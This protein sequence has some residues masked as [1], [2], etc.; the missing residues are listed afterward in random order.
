MDFLAL[1]LALAAIA[2]ARK[3]TTRADLFKAELNDLREVVLRNHAR[4]LELERRAIAAGIAEEPVATP[5][6]PAAPEPEATPAVPEVVPSPWVA[7]EPITQPVLIDDRKP[8]TDEA[9]PMRPAA[10]P[11]A[12]ADEAPGWNFEELFG[13][14]LPVWAGG[15]AL[16][17]AGF[18]LVKY[19]IEVGLV[20]PAVRSLLGLLFGIGL[21]AGAEVARRVPR[22]AADPRVAQSLSGAGVASLYG[23]AYMATNLYGLIGPTAGF[24]AMAAVTVAALALSLR[25]GAPTALLGLLGGFVAP[26]LVNT[27]EGSVPALLAYLLLM[28][29]GLLGVA[30][31]QGWRWLGLLALAGGFGWSG[32]LLATDLAGFDLAGTGLYLVVLAAGALLLLGPD[33]RDDDLLTAAL[34]PAGAAVVAFVQLAL[35]IA[36]GGFGWTEWGL[37]ALLA[38]GVTVLARREPAYRLLPPAALVVA[39]VTFA[40]WPAPAPADAA[41]VAGGLLL[42]FALPGAILS[43]REDG[44]LWAG[45]AVAATLATAALLDAKLGADLADWQGAILTLTLAGPALLL[46]IVSQRRF[47]GAGDPRP[48][49]FLSTAA[50]LG[51]AAAAYVVPLLILPAAILVIGAGVAWA[52]RRWADAWLP[53]AAGA[54]VAAALIALIG[55][56]PGALD[57]IGRLIGVT[58]GTAP[59]LGLCGFLLP[60]ALVAVIGWLD[61]AEQRRGVYAALAAALAAAAAVQ[62]APTDARPV[63]LAATAAALVEAG[64]R[65]AR[66]PLRMP[67]L[68]VAGLAALWAAVPT[69]LVLIAGL[70]TLG[71]APL[72][73]SELPTLGKT[74]LYLA[75]PAAVLGALLWRDN[76]LP[77]WLAAVPAAMAAIAAF[78][79]YKQLFAIADVDAFAARGMIERVLLTQSLFAAG[80]LAYLRRD[81]HALMLPAGRALMALALARLVWF[82]IL[83]FNPLLQEQSVGPWPVANLLPIA[84][85]LPVFWLARLRAAEP[86]LPSRAVI[87]SKGLAVA[88]LVLLV[89]L[90]VRQLFQGAVLTGG[91]V[92]AAEYYAYSLAGLAT[93]IGLLLWGTV[94]RDQT[95]RL[96]SLGLLLATV[97]KVFLFD[98]AE[99]EGLWRIASF[100]GLGLSL[101]G[102]SWF[103]TRH[104]FAAGAA[105]AALAA[106]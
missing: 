43:Q 37:Y 90:S 98:A 8:T 19:S 55:W 39:L 78:V 22:L 26:A 18:F 27:G 49:A 34:L 10:E 20:T 65:Q 15:I 85:G 53:A 42:L 68:A 76:H 75:A 91:P 92:E 1:L 94:R 93:A 63:V 7:R 86:A 60:A 2:L 57:G 71:G 24:G 31:A 51:G 3:A 58:G 28:V 81:A 30:R 102:I 5:A 4:L 16:A 69:A 70:G 29:G 59:L 23:V 40:L 104:V 67:G 48:A 13:R 100:F 56:T 83:V 36:K 101:I 79:A 105:R 99:L 73:T 106:R 35:L 32:L 11:A 38:T 41:I 9:A 6:T 33:R 95:T 46:A 50:L 14:H 96:A 74:M 88:S 72:F 44:L 54:A 21:I 61:D 84:Y 45:Q 17:L 80:A 62:F 103:Y 64:L 97:A 12:N 77:R 82:D 87:A 47:G 66:L 25:Y 52:A 89:G